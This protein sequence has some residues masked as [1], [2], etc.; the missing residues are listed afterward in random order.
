MNW[1]NII[2][3]N[4]SQNNAFEELVCQLASLEFSK[5][6]KFIKVGNPDAGVEC[7]IIKEN[8]DEIGFQAKYFLSTPQQTQWNQLDSSIKTALEKHPNLKSY[9]VA[10]P[11]DRADPRVDNKESFKDK[12]EKWVKKWQDTVKNVYSKEIEIVYWGS[13]ELIKMLKDEKSAGLVKYFFKEIDLSNEW[14]NDQNDNAIKSLGVRYSPEINVELEICRYFELFSKNSQYLA[15]IKSDFYKIYNKFCEKFDL[16]RDIPDELK[17]EVNLVKNFVSNLNFANF[18]YDKFEEILRNR[19]KITSKNEL[20]STIDD[21]LNFIREYKTALEIAKNQYLILM[22]EAGVGKSHLFA[23]II[24]HRAKNNQQSIL[25]LGQHLIESKDPWAQILNLLGFAKFNKYEFL[26]ALNSKAQA[27]SNKIIIFIDAINEG[28]GKDFWRNFII[29]FIEDIKKYEWL[30]VAF[31]IRSSYFECM[32]PKEL[33]EICVIHHEGFS[34]IE[35][36]AMQVFF[37]YYKL[38]HPTIP[39]LNPEFS[40]PLFLKLFC[41]GVSNNKSYQYKSLNFFDVIKLYI[42]NIERNFIQKYPNCK[43]LKLTQKVIDVVVSFISQEKHGSIEYEKAFVQVNEKLSPFRVDVDFLDDLISEGLFAKNIFADTEYI[44]FAYEKLGDYLLANYFIEK[45]DENNLKNSFINN[46]SPYINSN[47]YHH[48]GLVEAFSVLIP[49]NFNGTE[50]YELLEPNNM[51]VDCFLKSLPYR[52]ASI[53]QSTVERVLKNVSNEN[54]SADIFNM[55]YSC[56]TILNHPFNAE[57]MFVYLSKFSMKERDVFF[58]GILN[59]IYLDTDM[60]PIVRLLDWCWS[61]KDKSYIDDES[62][63][64]AAIAIAWLFCTSNRRLR[65]SATK[66]LI[67]ILIDRINLVLELLQ[68]FK[69]IDEPYIKERLFAVAYGVLVKSADAINFKELG[70]YIYD[71]IFNQ[72]EVYPNILLRDYAKNC[73]EFIIKKGINLDIKKEKIHPPYNSYFPPLENLP[74]NDEIESYEDRDKN[75]YQ[76]RIISS[77]VTEYGKSGYMYGDFGRYVFEAALRGFECEDSAQLISNYATKNIFEKYGYDGEYFDKAEK[78]IIN[79]T[80]D[81]L[82]R[83]DHKIERIGKKYQWISFYETMA[84]I[85]DNFKMYN[86]YGNDTREVK[87]IGAFE[88]YVRDIDPTILLKNYERNSTFAKKFWWD[89][90]YNFAWDMENKKWLEYEKDLPNLSDILER[91]ND[92]EQWITLSLYQ[93][94]IEPLDT[95]DILSISHKDVK[96]FIRSYIVKKHDI[97]RFA[98][99]LN[100]KPNLIYNLIDL[101]DCYKMFNM[102]H[103]D[104]VTYDALKDDYRFE[105]FKIEDIDVANTTIEYFWEAE[106]DMSKSDIFQIC[107]PSKILY[108]GLGL[109]YSKRD[110]YFLDKDGNTVCFDPSSDNQTAQRLLIKKDK[111]NEFLNVCNMCIVWIISGEKLVFTTDNVDL[112]RLYF[113][114]YAFFGTD[115]NLK[116]Y[117]N[118]QFEKHFN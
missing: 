114:G 11:I 28:A 17:D 30:S 74:S 3:L 63:F 45:L 70:E 8:G 23:D 76:S 24:K 19:K 57:F 36:D 87:Y 84:R 104:Y 46:I 60:N 18:D 7:Y 31:S 112:G 48:K 1:N 95:E 47:L 51:V 85:T 105:W 96:L 41:K 6:G 20:T 66:A 115:G 93:K 107:K 26:G 43:S 103:Y 118:K 35:Y 111:L 82:N 68:K 106:F 56:S 102:E 53:P 32:I 27:N 9:Y 52:S 83:Y 55:L 109:K 2:S 49:E 90:E 21:F 33:S 29:S 44:Y 110:I 81:N 59:K 61:S 78:D 40:N 116:E 13:H 54:F 97:T 94:F 71:E 100:N 4:G 34:G 89:A 39:L 14:F 62:I 42:D 108:D 58:I 69:N 38:P 73:I 91:K 12:W 50:I 113:N 88:P 98:E 16:L 10:I 99:T 101:P 65:D 22:G 92:K 117:I 72:K 5:D 64:L 86:G 75:Y 25:I 77:M 15:K 67:C 37:D 80:R 79:I